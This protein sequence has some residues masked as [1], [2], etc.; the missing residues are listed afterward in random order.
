MLNDKNTLAEVNTL[1]DS[2]IDTSDID[3]V[4]ENM[5]SSD[6]DDIDE[7]IDYIDEG[8]YYSNADEADPSKNYIAEWFA[9]QGYTEVI[10]YT[11]Y[12]E[13]FPAGFL[14]NAGARTKDKG[15][16]LVQIIQKPLTQEGVA[17]KA[18]GKT[19]VVYNDLVG[20]TQTIKE[21][22]KLYNENARNSLTDKVQLLTATNG[23][24][25]LGT[26]CEA[27]N[28]FMLSAIIIELDDP[29]SNW[30]DE[31]CLE[32]T[33]YDPIGIKNMLHQMRPVQLRS[34]KIR[35]PVFPTPTFISCSGTGIHLY[36]VL[37]EP[38]RINRRYFPKH[39]EEVDLFKKCLMGAMWRTKTITKKPVEIQGIAQRYRCVGS[40][41]KQ[42][43]IVR[44]FQT[45][46]RVSLDYLN[47]FR[48]NL[49][50]EDANHRMAE[51]PELKEIVNTAPG[52]AK[53]NKKRK[54]FPTGSLGKGAYTEALN[55]IPI[56][57]MEGRR[58]WFLYCLAATA[59][60]CAIPKEQLTKDCYSLLEFMNSLT[61][62]PDNEFTVSDIEC[63]ISNYDYDG[64][65][66]RRTTY[67]ALCGVTCPPPR[68]TKKN[69]RSLSEHLAYCR[70]IKA[71]KKQ[72]GENVDCGRSLKWWS[73]FAYR[74]L[75]PTAKKAEALNAKVAAKV[76]IRKYWSLMDD[77]EERNPMAIEDLYTAMKE[78]EWDEIA[79]GNLRMQ[80]GFNQSIKEYAENML[81]SY[82]ILD[83][84]RNQA[85][86]TSN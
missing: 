64:P 72:M 63:A 6:A 82:H 34:G 61:T 2:A 11:F 80:N 12:R 55:R 86:T 32:D 27:D 69:G 21:A 37:D 41:T 35:P 75:Y 44:A 43:S 59:R 66:M 19:T 54:Y 16:G 81:E 7:G 65:F 8:D 18:T 1:N 25:Y 83:V 71:V 45:G 33:P 13:L 60:M 53:A 47:S 78:H 14:D 56:Y 57:A 51:C 67:E 5:I 79:N 58:Y 68:N 73:T 76:T 84:Y 20:M 3:D 40:P 50:Y 48:E 74:V 26:K 24:S 17:L 15:V 77:L 38:M 52:T 9:S 70:Q 30:D 31:D 39:Y 46:D 29:I 49:R 4:Y 23:C 22:V 62:N 42:G 10:P 36:Y 28:M 85:K